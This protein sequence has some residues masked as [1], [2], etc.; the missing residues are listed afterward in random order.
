[1]SALFPPAAVSTAFASA[2]A[3]EALTVVNVPDAVGLITS[4]IARD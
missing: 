4:Q 3:A 1:M 2:A